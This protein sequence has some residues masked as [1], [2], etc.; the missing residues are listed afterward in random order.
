MKLYNKLQLFFLCFISL[1]LMGSA[2][3]RAQ[4]ILDKIEKVPL[5]REN[6]KAI[7][8]A[9][10]EMEQFSSEYGK[11]VSPPVQ[12]KIESVL[13]RLQ[14]FQSLIQNLKDC[15][16]SLIVDQIMSSIGIHHLGRTDRQKEDLYKDLYRQYMLDLSSAWF[17]HRYAFNLDPDWEKLCY[18][19]A[20]SDDL[21]DEIARLSEESLTGFEAKGMYQ[22][23]SK[24]EV[25][26]QLNAK[27]A[28]IEH[29]RSLVTPL[30]ETHGFGYDTSPS[31]WPVERVNVLSE[32]EPLEAAKVILRDP[33]KKY[34]D[35][36]FLTISSSIGKLLL[37]PVFQE[38][39]GKFVPLEDGLEIPNA[40][41]DCH[42]GST[43]KKIIHNRRGRYHSRKRMG[44]L[45]KT[46]CVVAYNHDNF[47]YRPFGQVSSVE[48]VKTAIE[49]IGEHILRTAHTIGKRYLQQQ[50]ESTN[51]VMEDPEG[52]YW[53][54][55]TNKEI[56]YLV[57]S[58]PSSV[59]YL[60][61]NK[62]YHAQEVCQALIRIQ[63]K[64]HRD[65]M[66]SNI[67]DYGGAVVGVG[68]L[69][70]AFALPFFGIPLVT[71][72][73][74]VGVGGATLTAVELPYRIEEFRETRQRR[75]L[76]MGSFF[77]N[78]VKRDENTL[79]E[80]ERAVEEF[81]ESKLALALLAGF[82][83]FDVLEVGLLLRSYRAL[84]NLKT[85]PFSEIS[86]AEKIEQLDYL[87]KFFRNISKNFSSN[88]RSFVNDNLFQW[89]AEY[90]G[91]NKMGDFLTTLANSLRYQHHGH[92][93]LAE[94][95]FIRLGEMNRD[96]FVGFVESTLEISRKH[97]TSSLETHYRA[98]IK[99]I[100][101]VVRNPLSHHL[102][103]SG[104]YQESLKN[105]IEKLDIELQ[106]AG[107][108][109]FSD[110][111]KEL[112]LKKEWVD[113][114]LSMSPRKTAII[115]SSMRDENFN[116]FDVLEF[117]REWERRTEKNQSLTS[118]RFYRRG[119][120]DPNIMCR[121]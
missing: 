99:H 91:Q 61:E 98:Q 89:T 100:R 68:L 40:R 73:W 17:L 88:G 83:I 74:I 6:E 111:S 11:E 27:V 75:N 16:E 107:L 78:N 79:R 60:L 54:N 12:E 113:L 21:K 44:L 35:E 95:L 2:D 76:L 90:L 102:S 86:D 84:K 56:D 31:A 15:G 110:L 38:K 94:K 51:Y 33:Y 96:E 53:E 26:E 118:S 46:R 48:D 8:L 112:N 63:K 119:D 37:S 57:S 45:K 43:T 20:C 92:S 52:L 7:G 116:R 103:Q 1:F 67:F 41:F 69:C 28:R 55:T 18:E 30:E 13:G 5:V 70:S 22:L 108:I 29:L 77:V 58:S 82:S 47:L 36:Y 97:S 81:Q 59:G 66:L 114:L 80:I 25:L 62:P 65:K 104:N 109:S 105:K 23:A 71:T 42:F 49:Q 85:L 24:E 93:R 50:E 14:T 117:F 39:I 106:K 9:V 10:E 64:E 4:M 121:N 3:Y 72:A 34:R 120:M 32:M 115:L 87:S 101:Q 19:S